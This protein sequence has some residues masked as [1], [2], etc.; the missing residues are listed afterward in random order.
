M[1]EIYVNNLPLTANE[2]DIQKWIS[3]SIKEFSSTYEIKIYSIRM[4]RSMGNDRFTGACFMQVNEK[5]T[6]E[7]L[8]VCLART[9]FGRHTVSV[10]LTMEEGRPSR[11]RRQNTRRDYR[12]LDEEDARCDDRRY[13][14]GNRASV[15]PSQFKE[16]IVDAVRRKN[17]GR[18]YICGEKIAPHE[19]SI[20]HIAPC[21]E[22]FNRFEYQYPHNERVES[23]ND[24]RNLMP[25]HKRCNSSK[26]SYGRGYESGKIQ[27][28]TTPYHMENGKLHW[29]ATVSERDSFKESYIRT[30]LQKY[31]VDIHKI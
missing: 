11:E 10:K 29:R 9:P 18:C 24:I 12:E 15:Y 22:L 30:E 1:Y 6:A 19:L 20:D 16:G 7:N 8:V 23:Y 5:E 25:V 4:S 21:A 3:R 31:H 28:A 14:L 2:K 26:G 13:N 17:G 27:F